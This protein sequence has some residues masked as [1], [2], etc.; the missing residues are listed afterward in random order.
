L[1][2]RLGQ[3]FIVENRPG[4]GGYV[5]MLDAVEQGRDLVTSDINLAAFA[6]GAPLIAG[7]L[8]RRAGLLRRTAEMR[9]AGE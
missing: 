5:G 2:E 7:V 8:E 3:P 9:W 1:S 4:G 6:E